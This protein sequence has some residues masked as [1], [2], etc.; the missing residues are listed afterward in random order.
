MRHILILLLMTVSFSCQQKKTNEVIGKKT[1]KSPIYKIELTKVSHKN[2]SS[3]LML[4]EEQIE[5]ANIK[6]EKADSN[7]IGQEK[8]LSGQVVVN[9]NMESVISSRL[10]GRIDK[11]YF[12]NIG[13]T[14]HSGQVIYEIYSEE[15]AA[16]QK[17]LLLL[18][19]KEKQLKSFDIDYK[20]LV[21]AARNKLKLWG[22]TDNQTDDLIKKDHVQIPFPILSKASGVITDINIKEGDYAMAGIAI[23][24]IT[25]LSIVWVQAQ[26]YANEVQGISSGKEV[27][28]RIGAFPNKIYK[29]NIS[30]VNP[31]LL[32]QTKIDLV[33][34]EIPNQDLL[35]KPG[36][37]A[38]VSISE[39]GHVGLVVNTNAVLR[40][41]KGA[42][43]WVKN[44]DGS[45]ENKMVHIGIQS[46]DKMEILHG[47][48]KG[49]IIVTSGAY[50]INSEYI[51]KKGAK[52]MEGHNM[53]KM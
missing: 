8:I 48:K 51:F 5:L 20:Q 39:K 10:E 28:I 17:D 1:G 35:L 6:T 27:K 19:K 9:E 53:E 14:I 18:L 15:L 16:A 13:E 23:F 46:D 45:F 26:I 43:V 34:V 36:M 49:D 32:T 52:P 4:S 50:L 2:Q 24:K 40:D 44:E 33:R 11:L 21:D 3:G 37:Q 30:F 47:L 7:Y 42:S 31:Q 38:Y 12:K 25:D 29:G 22:I 41:S